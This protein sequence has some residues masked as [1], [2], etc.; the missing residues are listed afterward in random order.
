MIAAWSS[1]A[2]D[3]SI[4]LRMRASK[5]LN[6]CLCERILGSSKGSSMPAERRIF[7]T[8]SSTASEKASL[9]RESRSEVKFLDAARR[10]TTEDTASKSLFFSSDAEPTCDEERGLLFSISLSSSFV[11]NKES[12]PLEN[13][14]LLTLLN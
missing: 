10:V 5:P 12:N 11:S 1:P 9:K 14:F 4:V 6:G 2:N 13:F 8:L 7:S 3:V